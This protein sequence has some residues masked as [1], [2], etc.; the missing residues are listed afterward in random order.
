MSKREA[1][2]ATF[3][4]IVKAA[5]DTAI[6]AGKT[7][8]PVGCALTFTKSLHESAGKYPKEQ[9]AAAAQQA[10]EQGLEGVREELDHL[11]AE[12]EV[13]RQV[14]SRLTYEFFSNVAQNL[15]SAAVFLTEQKQIPAAPDLATFQKA[16]YTKGLP[17]VLAS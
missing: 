16:I 15:Q 13:D 2:R 12:Q 10:T 17:N 4:A 8:K 5:W 3:K 6:Y 11:K 7:T 1:G 14:L 9:R